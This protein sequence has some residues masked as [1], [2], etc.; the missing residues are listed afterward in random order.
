MGGRYLITGAQIGVLKALCKNRKEITGLL[1]EI[2]ESQFV[3]DS[4]I[5]IFD[6]IINLRAVL[7]TRL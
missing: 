3:Q 2:Q 5:S 1:E 7:R 4:R 6:D